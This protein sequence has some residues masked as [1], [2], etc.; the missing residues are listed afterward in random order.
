MAIWHVAPLR[1][2]SAFRALG[3]CEHS[4][5]RY[6]NFECSNLIGRNQFI[7]L[8]HTM[9]AKLIRVRRI[10][11]PPGDEC[12]NWYMLRWERERAV[13]LFVSEAVN[14]ASLTAAHGY[15]FPIDAHNLSVSNDGTF[16]RFQ[17][18][19]H[20]LLLLTTLNIPPLTSLPP[21]FIS[22]YCNLLLLAWDVL[23]TSVLISMKKCD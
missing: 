13:W 23:S 20:L 16:Y 10:E 19:L 11:Q 6:R 5:L 17:V 15:F 21:A 14:L 22:I 4:W 12:S 8:R 9:L 1:F 2:V 7:P 18:R 3:V